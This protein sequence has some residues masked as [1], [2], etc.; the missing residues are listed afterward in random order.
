MDAERD[1]DIYFSELKEDVKE[2]MK[3]KS[4][5]KKK[6]EKIDEKKDKKILKENF[7]KLVVED[8]KRQ[9]EVKRLG[10]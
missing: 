7:M 9:N 3:E 10:K 5:M 2:L 1:G 6:V 8:E 4:I